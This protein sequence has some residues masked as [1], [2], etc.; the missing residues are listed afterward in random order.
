MASSKLYIYLARLDRR[1]IEVVGTVAT[2]EKVFPTRIRDVGA[3]GMPPA[4][5]STVLTAARDKKMTHELYAESAE[6]FEDLR[7]SLTRRGFSRLPLHQFSGGCY[8]AK[9]NKSSL[10]TRSSTMLRKD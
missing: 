4:L 5:E 8:N 2:S 9:L 1:G 10:S 3:L 6:S 7:K